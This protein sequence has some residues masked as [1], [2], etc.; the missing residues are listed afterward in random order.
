[1]K[2]LIAVVLIAACL[3]GLGG[4]MA[5]TASFEIQAAAKIELRSGSTGAAV[6]V[7]DEENIRLIT[8]NFTDLLFQKG[9]SSADYTGWSYS[10]TWYDGNGVQM[11]SITVMG[12]TKVSYEGF[13][14]TCIGAGI[15]T[16]L[17]DQ[18]LRGAE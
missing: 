4:C 5:N 12:Q 7:V 10:I 8:E 1:M 11:D 17:F 9:Y 6:E 15:N 18:L 14:Y 3:L 2:K 13:F 16:A